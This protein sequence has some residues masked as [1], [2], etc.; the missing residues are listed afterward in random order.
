MRS[1]HRGPI[2]NVGRER[3]EDEVLMEAFDQINQTHGK[4]TIGLA[5][6]GFPSEREWKMKRQKRSPWYTTQWDELPV[7]RA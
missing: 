1:V 2:S 7:A 4:G 3:E 5:A 6:T